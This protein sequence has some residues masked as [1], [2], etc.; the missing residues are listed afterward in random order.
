MLVQRYEHAL[1]T[2]HPAR[3]GRGRCGFVVTD[4][5][6][7]AFEDATAAVPPVGAIVLRDLVRVNGPHAAVINRAIGEGLPDRS[8]RR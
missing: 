3:P 6:G 1:L 5:D 8:R 4:T 7:D 2:R